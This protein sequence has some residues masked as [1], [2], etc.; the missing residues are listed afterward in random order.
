MLHRAR[1]QARKKQLA[2]RN[3]VVE[4][5]T[6]EH[7]RQKRE[8]QNR[9][10]KNAR[11]KRELQERLTE[12]RRHAADVVDT[13]EADRKTQ[14]EYASK[15][16]AGEQQLKRELSAL[17]RVH[18]TLSTEKAALDRLVLRLQSD[19]KRREALYRLQIAQ[20]Q[21]LQRDLTTLR[22]EGLKYHAHTEGVLRQYETLLTE[23]NRQLDTLLTAYNGMTRSGFSPP[24][25]TYPGH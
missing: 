18:D 21:Q 19:G 8:F 2:N 17:T 16:I 12:Y 1:V 3:A 10:D 22:Q 14:E 15:F 20:S 25:N 9:A 6:N 11:Q 13:R 5:R 4:R 24:S 7:A 23:R